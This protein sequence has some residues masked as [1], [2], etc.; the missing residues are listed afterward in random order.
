[1]LFLNGDTGTKESP[2]V[3]P[4]L[5]L[6]PKNETK[7]VITSSK[8]IPSSSKNSPAAGRRNREKSTFNKKKFRDYDSPL[9]NRF[10]STR[11]RDL[12]YE[13]C[14]IDCKSSRRGRSCRESIYQKKCGCKEMKRAKRKG[15]MKY[16]VSILFPYQVHCIKF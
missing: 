12:E 11:K 5:R 9:Q 14:S 7:G 1:M 10:C 13:V 16:K 3:V 4:K 6:I 2:K 15:T 8:Y